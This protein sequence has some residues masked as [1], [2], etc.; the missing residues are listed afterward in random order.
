FHQQPSSG[1]SG[2]VLFSTSLS[3]VRATYSDCLAVRRILHCLGVSF[4]ERNLCNDSEA[5]SV[6][7]GRQ[8]PLV[9]VEQV[10]WLGGR[11]EIEQLNETGRLSLLLSGHICL[12]DRRLKLMRRHQQKPSQRV[13]WQHRSPW[14]RKCNG[15]GFVPVIENLCRRCT[16]CEATGI[17]DCY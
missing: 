10:G 8:V 6:C 7:S 12:Q 2:V 14:C 13:N 16:F 1:R 4:I 11:R 3:T 9:W 5:R 15:T 17:V